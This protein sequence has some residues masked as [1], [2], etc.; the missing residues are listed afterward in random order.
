[1]HLALW[2]VLLAAAIACVTD[3]R[4]RRIPNLLVIALAASGLAMHATQGWQSVA[5]SLAVLVLTLAVGAL[6]FSFGFVGGG[7]VKLIGAA[8][9]TLT[10]PEAMQ[11]VLYT[12][13]CGG[14]LGI[15]FSLAQGRLKATLGN[16]RAMATPLLYGGRPAA[17]QPSAKMPYAIAIFAGAAT[18]GLAQTLVPAL[19]I[20]L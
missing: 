2:L 13:L 16:V 10:P 5:M 15:A 19:R 12:L 17:V 14:A 11:F 3:V 8:A 20:A 7:D 1:M 6:V 4:T 18:L 9:V